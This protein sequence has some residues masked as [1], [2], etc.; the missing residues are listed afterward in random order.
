LFQIRRSFP[1]ETTPP[2]APPSRIGRFALFAAGAVVAFGVALVW[3][4][5]RESAR[6]RQE[7]LVE[8]RALARRMQS[9][10][11]RP[12][13]LAALPQLVRKTC[14]EFADP[15]SIR[16]LS[17][18]EWLEFLDASWPGGSF[19]DGPGRVLA[20]LTYSNRAGLQAVSAEQAAELVEL[21]RRWIR[22]HKRP[23]QRIA[24]AESRS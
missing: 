18:Q 5:R 13:A 23:L 16:A 21:V 20:T 19:S 22:G 17:G 10:K 24:S 6:Y 8:L 9:P 3:R 2:P 14:E 11:A 1:S 4:K 15:E 12:D 7:A